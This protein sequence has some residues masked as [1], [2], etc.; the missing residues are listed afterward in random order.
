MSEVLSR[1]FDNYSA[2]LCIHEELL[3]QS[4]ILTFVGPA[5]LLRKP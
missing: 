5:D 2:L 4:I 3:I 1:A